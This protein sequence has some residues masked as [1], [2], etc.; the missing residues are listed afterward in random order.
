MDPYTDPEF[1]SAFVRTQ[2][3]DW[4]HVSIRGLMLI[5]VFAI[6][7]RGISKHGV[8]AGFLLLPVAVEWLAVMWMGWFLSVFVVDCP[9][10]A[11]SGRKPVLIV[12]WTV[13]IGAIISAVLAAGGEA[14][15]FSLARVAPGWQE[16][17]TRLVE[18]GLVWALVAEVVGLALATVPEVRR[19][20][21]LG[22]KFIWTA[23]FGLGLRAAAMLLIGMVGFFVVVWFA[24]SLGAWLFETSR[25][26]AWLVFGFLL[27]VEAGA[28][29]LGVAMHRD[30]AKSPSSER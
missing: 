1:E 5:V 7:A 26:L 13:F 22:G 9:A 23:V 8:S 25:R 17:W 11:K 10:F 29:V 27:A 16:G 12:F 4:V 18:T 2:R 15:G 30:F 14:E 21:R 19:W 20:R 6:M 28:L 3:A 24:D